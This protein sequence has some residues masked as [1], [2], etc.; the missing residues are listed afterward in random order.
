MYLSISTHAEVLNRLGRV[1]REKLDEDVSHGGVD[2]GLAPHAH[3][4]AQTSEQSRQ[5]RQVR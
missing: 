5:S 4:V 2:H 1:I 3:P